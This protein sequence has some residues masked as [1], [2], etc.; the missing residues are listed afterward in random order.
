MSVAMPGRVFA[1]DDKKPL[2][3]QRAPLAAKEFS[4]TVVRAARRSASLR[5][6]VI[7]VIV[8]Y[9][10]TFSSALD[11]PDDGAQSLGE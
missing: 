11:W 5:G 2:A 1:I 4:H 10:S 8:R 7:V 6:I 9:R 3:T